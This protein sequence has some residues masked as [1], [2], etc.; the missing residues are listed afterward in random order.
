MIQ[1]FVKAAG[2]TVLF[3]PK[4]SS[5]LSK[6]EHNASGSENEKSL[7]SSPYTFGFSHRTV[8]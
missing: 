3:L 8:C 1:D 5:D 7:C 4:Y 2:H 6:I